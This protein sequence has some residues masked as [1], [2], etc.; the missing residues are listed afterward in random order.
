MENM[1]PRRQA[2]AY[3]SRDPVALLVGA[4]G[5]GLFVA[6]PWGAFALRDTGR[7]QFSP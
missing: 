3:G 5:W 1:R 4:A 7:G 2:N 6:T